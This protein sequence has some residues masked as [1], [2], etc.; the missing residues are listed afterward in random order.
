M[1]VYLIRHGATAGNLRRCYIGRTDEPLCEQGVSSLQGLTAPPCTH[2]FAS[3]MRRC[4]QTAQILYPDKTPVLADALKECDFGDFEWK[5]YHDL[6][7]DA[8]YQAWINSGGTAPFPHG[9]S[10]NGFKARCK[11]AFALLT[12]PLS[13]DAAFVVH[14]GTIM[15][16]CEAFHGGDYYSYHVPN[17]GIIRADWDGRTLT[18]LE[19]L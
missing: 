17:G 16:I 9:E 18:D 11:N 1:T 4:I 12:E 3:P 6:N 5:N 19:K 2:L 7:G 15:A 8:D 13:E 14:G 10:V